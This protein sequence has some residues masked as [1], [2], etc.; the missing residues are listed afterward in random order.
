MV[1]EVARLRECQVAW[2]WGGTTT[3][4]GYMHAESMEMGGGNQRCAATCRPSR[5]GMGGASHGERLRACLV[6]L[7]WRGTKGGL[8]CACQFVWESAV[9][10]EDHQRMPS[11]YMP[12]LRGQSMVPVD[13][14]YFPA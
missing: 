7:E 5:V 4:S 11:N 8:L 13:P 9:T 14:S 1:S 12:S 2:L 6:P 10:A 3:V